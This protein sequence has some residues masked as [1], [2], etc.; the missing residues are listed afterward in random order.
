M[1]NIPNQ[2]ENPNG[3]HMRYIVSKT[4]GQPID[5]NAEYFVLR[6][7]KGGSD[8]KHIEACRKAVLA[9]AEEIR[10]HL[11]E[12]SDDL[13]NR[14]SELTNLVGYLNDYETEDNTPYCK[15]CNGCGEDGCCSSLN[16]TNDENGKYCHTYFRDLQEDKR[17]F[18]L[19]YNFLSIKYKNVNNEFWERFDELVKLNKTELEELLRKEVL[20]SGFNEEGDDEYGR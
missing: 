3:L 9:Y 13:I 14:Y 20:K 4:N 17:M 11:P 16:C 7:D 19:L 10:D 2:D 15:V 8:P 12:L 18:N 6:L 1:N 5:D